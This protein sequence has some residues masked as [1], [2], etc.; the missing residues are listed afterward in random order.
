MS[1]TKS[2]KKK[3]VQP[4]STLPSSPSCFLEVIPLSVFPP[5]TLPPVLHATCTP[6]G[7]NRWM[8]TSST[9]PQPSNRACQSAHLCLDLQLNALSF[10]G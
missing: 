4:V 10:G 7:V 2:V 5:R 8:C 9:S 1:D 3:P 6:V